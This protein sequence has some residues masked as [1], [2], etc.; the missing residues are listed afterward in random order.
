MCLLGHPFNAEVPVANFF[1]HLTGMK[2]KGGLGSRKAKLNGLMGG[3]EDNPPKPSLK[4]RRRKS[5][6]IVF[7]KQAASTH[8]P[9]LFSIALMLSVCSNK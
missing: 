7:A 5:S 9:G 6:E 2:T 3:G 8:S 1:K 4:P